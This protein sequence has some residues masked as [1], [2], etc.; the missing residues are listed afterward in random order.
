[1]FGELLAKTLLS[2]DYPLE[3]CQRNLEL[4]TAIRAHTYG[5]DRAKPLCYAEVACSHG[6]TLR[7]LSEMSR[8]IARENCRT[9]MTGSELCA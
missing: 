3:Q 2:L 1:M 8:P 9:N 7:P 4:P 5:G 6:S